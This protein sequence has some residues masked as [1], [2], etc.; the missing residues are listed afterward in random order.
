ML[1]NCLVRVVMVKIIVLVK[2][3]RN[4]VKEIH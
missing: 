2:Q 3:E 4:P 1:I